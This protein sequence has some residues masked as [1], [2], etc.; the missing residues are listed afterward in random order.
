M[1]MLVTWFPRG[2]GKWSSCTVWR[3]HIWYVSHAQNGNHA[4]PICPHDRKCVESDNMN[5]VGC[6]HGL[7]CDIIWYVSHAHP[8]WP[9]GQQCLDDNMNHI[10][11]PHGLQCD[12]IWYVSHAQNG[13]FAHPIWSHGWKCV[14]DKYEP[15]RMPTWSTIW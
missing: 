5:H 7:Q 4:H 11:C 12:N 13:S 10:E 9:H 8:I 3:G 1:Y 2:I 14:D 6:P 15:W